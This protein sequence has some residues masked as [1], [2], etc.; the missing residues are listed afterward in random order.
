LA[1]GSN[2]GNREDYLIATVKELNCLP[3]TDIVAAS[4]V[5]LCDPVGE[6]VNGYFL[7]M[8]VCIE[9]GL[10]LDELHGR[11]V[12]IEGE[13]GKR[14]HNNNGNRTIDID[15]IFAGNF[16]GQFK[17]L[18]LPHPRYHQRDFVLRPLMDLAETLDSSKLKD[19]RR[20]I[21]RKSC[22]VEPVCLRYKKVVY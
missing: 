21:K 22:G 7:N 13:L 8:A 1:L 16:E 19:V 5:Y 20:H 10:S 11:L 6:Y 17:D 2:L 15:V 12:K 14:K 18:T 9:T 4:Y 3:K